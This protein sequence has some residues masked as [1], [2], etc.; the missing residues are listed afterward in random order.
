LLEQSNAGEFPRPLEE[1]DEFY[2][3]LRPEWIK[4]GGKIS[5]GAFCNATNTDRMSVDWA[6]K[7]T[8]RQTFDRWVEWGSCRGVA[9]ITA[10]LARNNGQNA[11]YKPKKT[12]HAHSDVVGGKSKQVRK[13]LA[14]GA[15]LAI[16][17]P[18]STPTN[19]NIPPT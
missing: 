8:P 12:N 1:D 17:T 7:S 6:D 14:R 5:P 2:R 9:S 10:E 3:A 18:I 13:A 4:D 16:P 19:E 15:N 11:E